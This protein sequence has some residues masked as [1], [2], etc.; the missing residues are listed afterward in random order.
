MKDLHH[1]CECWTERLSLMAAGCLSSDEERDVLQH[2]AACADCRQRFGQLTELCGSL[3][4][5]R[6]PAD[7]VETLIVERVLSEIASGQAD[8]S[9]VRARMK[10]ILPRSP[11][12]SLDTWRW[13][14]RSP[15][16][17]VAAAVV[18]FVA[19]SGVALWFHG[20][21]AT[22]TFAQV[23]KP[24]LEAKNAQYKITIE[25]EGR[26]EVIQEVTWLAPDR[27]R[28]V[29]KEDGKVTSVTITDYEKQQSL[30]LCPNEKLAV[31]TEYINLPKDTPFRSRFVERREQLLSERDKPGVTSLGK[32]TIDGRRVVGFR[33]KASC[34]S[35]AGDPNPPKAWREI[36][37]DPQTML[38]V[39]DVFASEQSG[40]VVYKM[41]ETDFVFDANIDES[42]LSL[43]PPAGYTVRKSTADYSKP[44]EKDL[45]VAFREAATLNE[46][47][48]PDSIDEPTYSQYS[49]RINTK[50]GARQGRELKRA[51]L[52]DLTEAF[53]RLG[54]GMGFASDLPRE[55]DAHYAGKGV[56]L[57]MAD[58]PIFW[59]RPK[60]AKKYRVVYADLSIRDAD[61]APNV[62]GAQSLPGTPPPKK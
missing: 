53:E 20:S 34:L 61:A 60:D 33:M 51:Q 29:L 58:R 37:A 9:V 44:A 18:F 27:V 12:H 57:D 15:V 46:G 19:I 24:I 30:E 31:V 17:R 47:V 10:T 35:M 7:G 21:G 50:Y 14:M 16:S 23:V 28:E 40:K 1:P 22:M 49:S 3:T 38:P 41:T 56:K 13:M 45:L 39:R 62:P 55:A 6:P 42:L 8:Q 36:W 52:V 2:I 11:T 48:F 26:P 25:S 32:K 5:A 59:Y 43:D 4:E 54:R